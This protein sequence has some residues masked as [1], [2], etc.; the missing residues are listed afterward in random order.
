M[1]HAFPLARFADESDA[2]ILHRI[3]VFHNKTLCLSKQP[4]VY[5]PKGNA[6]PPPGETGLT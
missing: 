2:S 3:A 4:G 6:D 1:Q 5:L